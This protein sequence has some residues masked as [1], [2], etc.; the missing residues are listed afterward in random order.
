MKTNKKEL[1]RI[2]RSTDFMDVWQ[3][4]VMKRLTLAGRRQRSRLVFQ[5][6]G[7]NRHGGINLIIFLVA[8]PHAA[9]LHVGAHCFG[10]KHH[11]DNP[12]RH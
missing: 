7:K 6:N 9:L 8:N 12:L 1:K 3:L 4:A 11:P 2:H 10:A 5:F